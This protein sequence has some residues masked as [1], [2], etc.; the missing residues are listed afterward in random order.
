MRGIWTRG[1]AAAL[2]MIGGAA[3]LAGCAGTP[4]NLS[5]GMGVPSF[6]ALQQVC[7]AT[8]VDYGNDAQSVYTTFF[9]AYVANQRGKVSNADYCAFQTSIAQHYTTLGAS[10]DP[11]ARNQWV[12]FFLDQRAKA[13]SWRAAV[14]PTLRAG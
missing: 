14:D 1:A 10:S 9:D 8:P 4:S 3:L 2:E 7:S 5:G 12:A 11:A 13:I 6:V